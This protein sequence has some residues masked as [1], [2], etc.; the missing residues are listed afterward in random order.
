MIP[1]SK[2]LSIL[3]SSALEYLSTRF[4]PAQY[5]AMLLSF[6]EKRGTTFRINT[7][8]SNSSRVQ[9]AL[10]GLHIKAHPINYLESAYQVKGQCDRELLKS[11]LVKCGEVYL[12]GITSMLPPVILDP[13]PEDTILDMAAA[14][15]SK[16]S[17][18][19]AIQGDRGT[20][21]AVEP[22]YIRLQRLASNMQTLGI[23][24][25]EV[26]HARGEKFCR[27]R[28][29][30]FERVLL[31]APCSGEGRFSVYD[32]SSYGHWSDKEVRRCAS[33]QKK[34]L[35]AAFRVVKPGGIIVYSTCTLNIDENESVIQSLIESERERATL[36]SV[37]ARF[38]SLPGA[39]PPFAGDGSVKF[40]QQV[41]R[42]LR[43]LPTKQMEGFFIGKIRKNM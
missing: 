23:K 7:L 40:D 26:V 36:L 28:E 16:T 37:P 25:V 31:D 4:T 20:I 22:D 2:V 42:C 21:V 17:Q 9:E 15:G 43:I 1:L 10:R 18:L 14:P 8:R 35:R 6:R 29:N 19:A 11:E 41:H 39:V 3:P 30:E 12:Q 5:D 13:E 38:H 27:E 24:S 34:L 33:L 32:K